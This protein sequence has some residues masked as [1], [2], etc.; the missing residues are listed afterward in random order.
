MLIWKLEMI[1]VGEV[2]D[3]S[4]FLQTHNVNKEQPGHNNGNGVYYNIIHWWF[5]PQIWDLSAMLWIY[6][7]LKQAL[8]RRWLS[9]E[10]QVTS[11]YLSSRS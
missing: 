4:H 8:F 6:L 9:F 3:T 1:F 5:Q 7:F 10:T 11:H 2:Y